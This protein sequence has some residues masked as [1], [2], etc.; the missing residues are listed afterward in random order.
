MSPNYPSLTWNYTGGMDKQP[1]WPNILKFCKKKLWKLLWW[2]N[3]SQP[4]DTHSRYIHYLFISC[5]THTEC[6][7]ELRKRATCED[8]H[9]EKLRDM[10]RSVP[11]SH[12][13]EGDRIILQTYMRIVAKLLEMDYTAQIKASEDYTFST[14]L[15]SEYTIREYKRSN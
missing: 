9:T 15:S 2:G 8:V 6:L 11:K 14:K 12:N 13:L 5:R 1:L 7:D 10:L 4:Q 3:S